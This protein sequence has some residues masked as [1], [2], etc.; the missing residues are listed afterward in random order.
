[1]LPSKRIPLVTD[2]PTSPSVKAILHQYYFNRNK[3]RLKDRSNLLQTV[4]DNNE[5]T[6]KI[7]EHD[8]E[9]FEQSETTNKT[10]SS[11]HD[12]IDSSMTKKRLR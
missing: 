4:H 2:R 11:N 8:E 6:E 1:M 9:I 5:E 7:Y 3:E 10:H 12:P